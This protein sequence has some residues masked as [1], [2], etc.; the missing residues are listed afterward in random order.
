MTASSQDVSVERRFADDAPLAEKP[1]AALDSLRRQLGKHT[2]PFAFAVRSLT[3]EPVR[4]YPA[5]FLNGIR[6]D[7]AAALES[8]LV[9][10]PRPVVSHAPQPGAGAFNRSTLGIPAELLRSRYCIR[11]ELGL[12][13]RCRVK[14]GMTEAVKPGMTEAVTPNVTPGPDRESGPLW[15]VNQGRRL[16]LQFDCAHCEMVI[17]PDC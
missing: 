1:E 17:S 10:R 8:A 7:L 14:P 6:R 2:G 13:E 16:R 15:L 3:A 11:R 4:F 9:S 12:C 5:A